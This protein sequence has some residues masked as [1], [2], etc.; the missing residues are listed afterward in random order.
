MSKLVSRERGSTSDIHDKQQLES[1]NSINFKKQLDQSEKKYTFDNSNLQKSQKNELEKE[2]LKQQNN[3]KMQQQQSEQISNLKVRRQKNKLKKYYRPLGD[4]NQKQTDPQF[5]ENNLIAKIINLKQKSYESPNLS[6]LHRSESEKRAIIDSQLLRV[7]RILKVTDIPPLKKKLSRRDKILG[8]QSVKVQILDDLN[9]NLDEQLD[10]ISDGESRITDHSDITDSNRSSIPKKSLRENYRKKTNFIGNQSHKRFNSAAIDLNSL[11][12]KFKIK[13]KEQQSP[14]L[15]KKRITSLTDLI[16]D[17]H[18]DTQRSKQSF[19]DDQKSFKAMQSFKDL[20]KGIRKQKSSMD[21]TTI[22]SIHI[23]DNLREFK[24]NNR[25]IG[26]P[27]VKIRAPSYQ[28]IR[29]QS[30]QHMSY[31][32][33]IKSPVNLSYHEIYQQDIIPSVNVVQSIDPPKSNVLDLYNQTVLNYLQYK[34]YES[35][36]QKKFLDTKPPLPGKN[37]GGHVRNFTDQIGIK[38]FASTPSKQITPMRQ[39]MNSNENNPSMNSTQK[40]DQQV[41]FRQGTTNVHFSQR[42]QFNEKKSKNTMIENDA[43]THVKALQ[44]LKQKLNDL[45]QDNQKQIEQ[46]NDDSKFYLECRDLV[47]E[48]FNKFERKSKRVQILH[49]KNQ[50]NRNFSVVPQIQKNRYLTSLEQATQDENLSSVKSSKGFS[51]FNTFKPKSNSLLQSSDNISVKESNIDLIPLIYNDKDT[52]KTIVKFEASSRDQKKAQLIKQLHEVR[53]QKN[54]IA[55]VLERVL[56]MYDVITKERFEK[57]RSKDS[58]PRTMNRMDQKVSHLQQLVQICITRFNIIIRQKTKVL[59][60]I[61]QMAL[62]IQ[63]NPLARASEMAKINNEY[64]DSIQE[65]ENAYQSKI[66]TLGLSGDLNE[67]LNY[68][69]LMHKSLNVFQQMLARKVQQMQISHIKTKR[70]SPRMCIKPLSMESMN[71][72]IED[73]DLGKNYFEKKELSPRQH[74][75]R[76]KKQTGNQNIKLQFFNTMKINKVSNLA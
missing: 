67:R 56:M 71:L 49:S 62:P 48:V 52:N 28:I 30:Q 36:A 53:F 45:L 51:K 10:K 7:Q 33:M 21:K 24:A 19:E 74:R 72:V 9:E 70:F 38:S 1:I 63:K 18:T 29:P 68:L 12:P 14:G 4:V 25:P 6:F 75:Q 46:M 26:T 44:E 43:A 57:Q 39:T 2:Q 20:Q 31:Q 13:Y 50:I 41:F 8:T 59:D 64:L 22:S 5:S 27:Y 76:K 47:M 40:H 60:D 15:D 3:Q 61:F 23:P 58:T 34:K 37:S 55:R 65:D 69:N 66:N 32:V 16:N 42:N 35:K 17:G 54:K 11:S 73:Y